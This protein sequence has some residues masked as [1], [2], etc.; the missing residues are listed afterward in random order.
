MNMNPSIAGVTIPDS[1]I[2]REV[3]ELIKDTESPLLFHHSIRV[4]L[5]GAL[6]GIRKG[7]KFDPELL[8]IGAMFHDLGLTQAYRHSMERFE[9]DGA[10]AARDFMRQH[11]ISEAEIDL[12][13]DAIA[14]H[15]TPGIPQH[16]KPE[17]ALVQAGA[18][19]D[20]VGMGFSEFTPEQREQVTTAYPRGSHFKENI[21]QAFLDGMKHRPESTVGTMNADILELKDPTYKRVNFCSL[22]LESNWHE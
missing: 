15:T 8:Y 9:V 12:V 17:V 5:F 3:T 4:Y 11:Q 22:I 6:T 14:L 18:A 21:I 1:K 7:L 2:A 10:N 13:W 19:M 16:K 20:V